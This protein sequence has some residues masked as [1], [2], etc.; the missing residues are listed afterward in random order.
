MEQLHDLIAL[1]LPVM[2]SMIENMAVPLL[3]YSDDVTALVSSPEQMSVLIHHIELFCRLFGMKLNASKTFAVIFN[4]PRKSHKSHAQLARSCCWK[5]DDQEIEIKHEAKFLGNIFHDIKGCEAA[6][7]ELA[8][9]G[10]RA[11]HLL[12]GRMK[13]HHI[14]QSSFLCRV[15]D[16][17]IKP[18]VSYGCHVWGPDIFYDK[19][20]IGNILSRT[21]N[22]LEGVH[23][24]F[25]RHLGG[26]PSSSPLWILYSEFQRTPLL[27]HWL[28]LC[29]RFWARSTSSAYN[30]SENILLRAAMRDNIALML[31]GCHDCWAARFLKTMVGVGAISQEALDACRT[32][33][34]CIIMPISESIVVDKLKFLWLSMC[35]ETFGTLADPRDIPDSIPT[36]NI[37]YRMWVNANQEPPHLKA[38]L[39]THIKHMLIRFRCTSFPLAIQVG[40]CSK[41][42]TPRSQRFCEACAPLGHKYVEDD[43]HFLLEC[44]AYSHIR[45]IF[46]LIFTPSASPLSVINHKDQRML[47]KAIHT[48]I[49]HRKSL[50]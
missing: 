2:G 1:K 49:M 10:Q 33:D 32:V 45:N 40:R 16:Q 25:M 27:F 4:D 21:K 47:G 9:K 30:P 13:S 22:P 8:A 26:L 6:P 36:T 3:M 38:F 18:V 44:P 14:N 43:K 15:F 39:P 23:I 35:Q 11:L 46:P 5:I 34:D 24:D 41:N 20:S 17:V 29:A 28:A 48:M 19:I 12:L 50:A 42:K 7:A 37:R 31:G